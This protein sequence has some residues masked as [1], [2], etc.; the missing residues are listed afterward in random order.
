MLQPWLP[1]P[2][3]HSHTAHLSWLF[4]TLTSFGN[5]W[6]DRR[7]SLGQAPPPHNS[8]IEKTMDEL[9]RGVSSSPCWQETASCSPPGSAATRCS[10]SSQQPGW[11]S[12]CWTSG[13]CRAAC[14]WRPYPSGHCPS[15]PTGRSERGSYTI[16]FCTLF[17]WFTS[18]GD[19]LTDNMQLYAAMSWVFFRPS[20]R[21]LT[22]GIRYSD[23]E[24]SPV[25]SAPSHRAL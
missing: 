2:D 7:L 12:W 23:T 9:S 22:P 10:S 14:Q 5:T 1:N 20:G 13:G 21:W 25:P 24:Q 8:E 16:C 6:N 15:G 17:E 18:S 11:N 3:L 19:Y 4:T